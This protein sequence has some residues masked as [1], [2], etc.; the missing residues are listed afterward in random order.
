MLKIC[1]LFFTLI[2][3]N[4]YHVKFIW[5]V[6]TSSKEFLLLFTKLEPKIYIIKNKIKMHIPPHH[7]Q[8]YNINTPLV[9]KDK[10]KKQ[11]S[12]FEW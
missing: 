9:K 10:K 7:I 6:H 1:K 5:I 4:S 11:R 8:K 12:D 2:D 3:S